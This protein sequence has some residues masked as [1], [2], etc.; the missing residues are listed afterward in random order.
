[1]MV[2]FHP[3]TYSK[4]KVSKQIEP[5]LSSLKNFNKYNFIFTSS[6]L[7]ENGIKI[8]KIKKILLEKEKIVIISIT[9]ATKII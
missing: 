3:E 9:W 1:M 2:T 8:K 4:I 5:M 7:D 6:N